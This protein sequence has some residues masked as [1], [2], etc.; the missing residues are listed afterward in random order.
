[1]FAFS[2]LKT[3]GTRMRLA[4]TFRKLATVIFVVLASLSVSSACAMAED[5]PTI[6]TNSIAVAP[7]PTADVNTTNVIAVQTLASLLAIPLEPL[8]AS[9]TSNG[10]VPTALNFDDSEMR[11]AI[12][13]GPFHSTNDA[14]LWISALL[15]RESVAD[16][17]PP[18]VRTASAVSPGALILPT[19]GTDRVLVVLDNLNVL[20]TRISVNVDFIAAAKRLRAAHREV[21][22]AGVEIVRPA[23]TLDV[24][25]TTQQ[26][27][28]RLLFAFCLM[29]TGFAVSGLAR[30]SRERTREAFT[31]LTMNDEAMTNLHTEDWLIEEDRLGVQ[32]S[33]AQ[34]RFGNAREFDR[35][36]LPSVVSRPKAARPT[37]RV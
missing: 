8:Q 29:A 37:L 35:G 20:H 26:L 4:A 3:L 24:P 9:M 21:A 1:M 36:F 25:G 32:S 33:F 18:S 30:R 22:V 5:V 14:Q 7:T 31:W 12:V 11:D 15:A 16:V 13:L 6:L 27:N 28:W 34:P 23:I 2:R 17:A 10:V 19:T